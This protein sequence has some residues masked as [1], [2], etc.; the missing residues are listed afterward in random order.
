MM[1]VI[2][3]NFKTVDYLH[4]MLASLFRFHNVSNV[5]VIVVENGSGDDLSVLR[6]SFP[7]VIYLE[8]QTNLG[9]AGACNLGAKH[10]HG[11]FI[12]LLNPDVVFVNDAIHQIEKQMIKNPDIGIGGISLKNFDGTQQACVWRFPKPLDQFLVLSKIPHLIPSIAPVARWRMTDFDYTQSQ[13]VDQVMGAFFCIR[14]NVFD[15]LQGLDDGFFMWYEEVDFCKRAKEA[16]FRVR[17]FSEI[18]ALH[19]K[20][21]SFDRVA[22]QKKQRMIRQ[23]IKRYMRK[24]E[25]RFVS[26]FFSLCDPVFVCVSYIAS[27]IKPL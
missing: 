21:S 4:T 10:A 13:D 7:Q 16:G 2:T 12:L 24:H 8:S 5:E 18:S 1:S 19:K 9:F 25:S 15:E 6:Q 17:F 27:R 20:G 11:D 14:R 3:V 22:T 26:F 23:S